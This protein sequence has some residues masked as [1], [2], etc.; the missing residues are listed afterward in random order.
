MNTISEMIA[1][2]DANLKTLHYTEN[3]PGRSQMPG[4]KETDCSGLNMFLFAPRDIGTYTGDQC[5]HGELITVDKIKARVGAG[6]VP[7]DTVFYRWENRPLGSDP[8]DHTNF[9]AGGDLVYNHGGPNFNDMGPVKQSLK[10]NVD[11][12]V[13]V[14]VRRNI[15]IPP[16]PPTQEFTVTQYDDIMAA[17]DKLEG[18]IAAL[19]ATLLGTEFP[20]EP[21]GKVEASLERFIQAINE[22]VSALLVLLP[23]S[24]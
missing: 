19:P 7:G 9:Y 13:A 6:M 22:H 23:K 1:W 11:S 2:L 3:E 14:M 10:L 21:G 18:Q 16:V 20:I 8:W 24:S 4:S 15:P 5:S 12:A 17:I